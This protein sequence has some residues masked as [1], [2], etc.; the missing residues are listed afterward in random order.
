MTDAIDLARLRSSLSGLAASELGHSRRAAV[1]IVLTG[2]P[3]TP[4]LLLVKRS[5]RQGDPWSGHMALP[6]GHAQ[7]ED[8]DLLETARREALEEVGIDLR[9]AELLGRLHDISPMRSSDLAVRPFVFWLPERPLLE[10]SDEIAEA[11]WVP[12]SALATGTLRGSYE[13]ELAEARLHVPAFGIEGRIVWGMTFNVLETL[14]LE[15]ARR[16]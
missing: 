15:S 4:E 13:V 12:L 1:A 7:P 9:P 10:L 5:V 14:L 11:L 8:G 2:D 3:R 6:G 16:G